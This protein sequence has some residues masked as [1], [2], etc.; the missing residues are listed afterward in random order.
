MSSDILLF[1]VFQP[2]HRKVERSVSCVYGGFVGGVQGVGLVTR[3]LVHCRLMRKRQALVS[4]A[5]MGPETRARARVKVTDVNVS[6]TQSA[7]GDFQV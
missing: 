6:V 3:L 5:M 1:V 2:G 7:S 4:A